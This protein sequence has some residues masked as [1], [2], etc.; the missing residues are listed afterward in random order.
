MKLLLIEDDKPSLKALSATLKMLGF[1]SEAFSDPEEAVARFQSKNDF[2]VVI[3]DL[4]MPKISGAEVLNK[5]R[6]LDFEI[7]VI[8]I[9]AYR[10]HV[11]LRANRIFYKPIDIQAL[12]KYLNLI[13]GW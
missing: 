3:T 5:I 4:R 2:D 10:D 12:V 11:P 13:K 8:V 9:T 1:D 7:P 6:D